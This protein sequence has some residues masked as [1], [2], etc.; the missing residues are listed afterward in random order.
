MDRRQPPQTGAPVQYAFVNRVYTR[1]LRPVI[2]AVGS[3][4]ALWTLLSA[5]SA[6]RDINIDK[7]NH[8][9]KLATFSVVLGIMYM[10]ACVI[11]VFGVTAAVTQRLGLIM[12]YA[13]ASV[14]SALLV[15]GASLVGVVVHFT[16][17]NDLISECTT[18]STGEN[19]SFRFGLWGPSVSETLTPSEAASFCQNGWDHDSWADIVSLII[20]IILGVLFSVMAFAYYRQMQDPTSVANTFRAPSNQIRGGGGYPQHYNPPY[21]SSSVPNLPYGAGPMPTTTY[22]PPPGP[23]PQFGGAS[24][25]GYDAD[26]M[27]KLPSYEGG[28][29]FDGKNHDDSKEDPFADFEAR[30]E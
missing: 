20:E 9:S 5:I 17:K 4:S 22:A 30:K 2:I 25:P 16:L 1:N 10:V 24:A 18:L 27:G 6:F 7:D 11:E 23:P 3:L 14:V 19:G 26:D 21:G 15:V 12:I 28:G 13:M 8:F 29:Y